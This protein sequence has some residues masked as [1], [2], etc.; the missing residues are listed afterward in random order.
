MD[1]S[2]RMLQMTNT[3]IGAVGTSVPIPLGNITREI[4]RASDSTIPT[5]ETSIDGNNNTVVLR[6]PGFY[7]I[8]YTGYHAAS[9]NTTV[10]TRLLVNGVSALFAVQTSPTAGAQMPVVINF[11]IRAIGSNQN[12][13]SNLPMKIQIVNTS[14]PLTGGTGNLIIERISD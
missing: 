1:Q 7:K 8:N 13:A 3:N 12:V 2:Y 6:E 10:G 11:V 5:F 14:T 4:S 9:N